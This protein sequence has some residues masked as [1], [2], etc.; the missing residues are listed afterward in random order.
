MKMRWPGKLRPIGSSPA[1]PYWLKAG[2]GKSSPGNKVV[3]TDLSNKLSV[4][5]FKA[6]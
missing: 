1:K 4:S 5:N 2:P 3:E 6:S